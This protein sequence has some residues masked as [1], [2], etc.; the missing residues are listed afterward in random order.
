MKSH[1]MTSVRQ[2]LLCCVRW[3]AA[4]A[5][6]AVVFKSPATSTLKVQRQY[7]GCA[8]QIVTCCLC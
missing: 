6:C 4:L 2:V 8:H 5:R 7:D 3:L 1:A